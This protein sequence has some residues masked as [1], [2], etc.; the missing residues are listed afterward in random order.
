MIGPLDIRHLESGM[1]RPYQV[2]FN[3]FHRIME[4]PGHIALGTKDGSLI[5][6]Y[7]EGYPMWLWIHPETGPGEKQERM[8]ALSAALEE[9]RIFGIIAEEEVSSFFAEDYSKRLG[10][11]YSYAMGMEAYCMEKLKAPGGVEGRMVPADGS[12]LAVVARCIAGFQKDALGQDAAEEGMQEA[13]GRLIASKNLYLWESGGKI[14][15]TSYICHRT[16]RHARINT[17]YTPPEER[18]K[19]Y[20]SA[21][22]A[23]VCG[24]ILEEGRKPLLYADLQNPDSNKVYRNVG[25]IPHGKL[26]ENRFIY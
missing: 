20:A 6:C 22:M 26:H 19:G 5:A 14:V 23:A 13:A 21:L 11:R 2:Q 10:V 16:G 4:S 25:F 1:F 17:V 3:L 9:N 18:K 15:S 8:E 12:H 7:N 24:I